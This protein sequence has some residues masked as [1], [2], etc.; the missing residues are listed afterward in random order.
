MSSQRNLLTNFTKCT[1]Y[2]PFSTAVTSTTGVSLQQHPAAPP[3]TSLLPEPYVILTTSLAEFGFCG[4]DQDVL[5]LSSWLRGC[6]EVEPEVE[7]LQRQVLANT[8]DDASLT[9]RAAR[10]HSQLLENIWALP[11]DALR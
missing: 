10:S 3:R 5:R 8:E 7:Q 4:V 9:G 1:T 2:I 11:V 6:G